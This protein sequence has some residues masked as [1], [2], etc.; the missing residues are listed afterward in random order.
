MSILAR[1]LISALLVLVL[2]NLLVVTFL[3]GETS[4]GDA[5]S[6]F[7][8]DFPETLPMPR[9]PELVYMTV[10]E[11]AHYPLGPE[12]TE[13]WLSLDPPSGGYVHLGPHSR[14]FAVA[15]YH[16]LH[17]L[18]ILRLG[19]QIGDPPAEIGHVA[20]CL[21]YLRHGALCGADR[22]LERGDFALRNF[23]TRRTGATHVCR[24][25][26]QVRD[27]MEENWSSWKAARRSAASSGRNSTG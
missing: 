18:R 8:H 27:V 21:S 19:L 25:W 16:Q 23:S 12:G 24:D 22:T 14:L 3:S 6:W 11:T 4:V 20:H 2:F 1:I 9:E 13:A 10:E 5:Y 17:C 15:M 26:T 7:G